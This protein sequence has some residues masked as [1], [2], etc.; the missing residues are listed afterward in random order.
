MIAII[1]LCFCVF[2]LITYGVLLLIFKINKIKRKYSNDKLNYHFDELIIDIKY[3]KRINS[4]N[5]IYAIKKI[6]EYRT[7]E[8]NYFDYDERNNRLD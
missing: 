4:D 8:N 1:I 2:L 7:K 3:D 5:R 6:E